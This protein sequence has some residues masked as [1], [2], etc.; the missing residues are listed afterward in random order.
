M[1]SRYWLQSILLILIASSSAGVQSPPTA[2]LGPQIGDRLPEFSGADQ[3]GRVQTLD[4][5]VREQGAM[6]VFFRSADW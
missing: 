4:S 5:V 1:L 3:F 6:I 2:Q